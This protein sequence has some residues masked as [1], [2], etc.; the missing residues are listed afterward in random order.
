MNWYTK[1]LMGQF[2]LMDKAA[3]DKGGGGGAPPDSA[4]ELADLKAKND[5]LEARL[6]KIEAAGKPP[7]DDKD[8]K[9][10]LTLEEKARKEREAKDKAS[11]DSKSLEAALT[12]NLSAKD[13]LKNNASLLP[14]NVPAIFEQAEKEKYDNAIEKANAIKVS[15]ISEFFAKQANLDQLT[16]PQKTALAQ[17]QELTKNV[18]QERVQQIYES[19]FEPVLE[20]IR[21]VKKAEALQKGL[22]DPSDAQD[23]YKKKLMMGSRKFHLGEKQ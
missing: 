9:D 23:A 2:L 18:K 5:A 7:A 10:D 11:G 21:K 20:T 8:K 1:F 15:V 19:I 6:A 3:D 16:G 14:E 12:F 4:K 22:A 13:W 17:F